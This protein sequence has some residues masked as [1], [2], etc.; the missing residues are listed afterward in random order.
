MTSGRKCSHLCQ[1]QIKFFLKN[2]I[3][4]LMAITVDVRDVQKNLI[5]MN[6][7]LCFI[8]CYESRL[9]LKKL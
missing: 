8:F 7:K 1:Y 5:I 6:K 2:V 9:Y 3:F 4:T